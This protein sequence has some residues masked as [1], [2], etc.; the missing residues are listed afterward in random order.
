MQ[1]HSINHTNNTSFGQKRY[2]DKQTYGYLKELLPKMNKQAIYVSNDTNY[3]ASYLKEL[4]V[5]KFT[6]TDGRTLLKQ[7]PQEEQLQKETLIEYG[8]TQLVI[9]NKDGEIIDNNKPVLTSWK[10]LLG[11][12][13]EY[14]KLITE[15]FDNTKMVKRTR[16]K[17]NGLTKEGRIKQNELDKEFAKKET[18]LLR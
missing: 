15:N 2:L 9:N 17:L 4:K 3:K 12:V 6:L 11:K 10:K 16:L 13:S 8:K 1:V 5:D 18:E 14:M 7:V